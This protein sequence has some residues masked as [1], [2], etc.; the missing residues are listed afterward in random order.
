LLPS[1]DAGR[2]VLSTARLLDF[3]N[4]RPCEV[5]GCDWPGHPDHGQPHPLWIPFTDWRQFLDS[6]LRDADILLDEVAGVAS[7]RESGSLPFQVARELQKMRKRG[8]TLSYTGPTFQRVEKI[9]RECTKLLTHC[10]GRFPVRVADASGIKAWRQNRMCVWRSYDAQEFEKFTSRER[11]EGS[12][13]G[14]SV[15]IVERQSFWLPGSDVVRAYD[16]HDQVLSL[17]WANEAGV[18]LECGGRRTI[19]RC[20]CGP[21][22]SSPAERDHSHGEGPAPAGEPGEGSRPLRF[23]RG[24]GSRVSVPDAGSVQA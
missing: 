21:A 11:Q 24:S 14:G 19:P 5:E 20:S 4:P 9:V 22:S 8:I 2:P 10:E 12:K 3:R 17:G 16:T 7:S 23:V 1:L 18:C 13:R 15:R 6:D